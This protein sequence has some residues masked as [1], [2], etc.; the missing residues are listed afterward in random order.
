MTA[1]GPSWT[2]RASAGRGLGWI[3][4]AGAWAIAG[5][6]GVVVAA[7]LAACLIV[8]GV[9][10]A[11]V[12]AIAGFVPRARGHSRTGDADVIEAHNV[13]GHSWVAY[14]WHGQS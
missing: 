3:G 13:G 11:A 9:V 7:M 4:A 1:T 2:P 14:G 12:V 6:V 5:V 8:V 10:G